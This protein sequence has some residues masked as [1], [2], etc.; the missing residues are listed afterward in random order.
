MVVDDVEMNEEEVDLELLGNAS[1]SDDFGH[2]GNL[3]IQ[4][5]NF[6]LVSCLDCVDFKF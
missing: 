1:Y 6:Y 3:W 5:R 4:R 2:Q